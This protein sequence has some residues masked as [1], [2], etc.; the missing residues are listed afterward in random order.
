M[1][2]RIVIGV[3]IACVLIAT[4]P[5]LIAL[6]GYLPSPAMGAVLI[7]GFVLWVWIVLQRMA[8]MRRRGLTIHR[9]NR[10]PSF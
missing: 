2:F 10:P 3:L 8:Q 6:L 1:I 9:I 4:A 5:V 7:S